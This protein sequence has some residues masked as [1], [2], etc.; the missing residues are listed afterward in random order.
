MLLFLGFVF[1]FFL[2]GFSFTDTDNSQD[3]REGAFF[4]TDY[5]SPL[6][7]TH[8]HSDIYLQ[9]WM[10]D[11]YHI[12]LIAPLVFTT[13]LSSYHLIYDAKFLFVY[14]MIWD[15]TILGFCYNSLDTENRWTRTHIDYYTYIASKQ[16]NKLFTYLTCAYLKK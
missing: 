13:I 1:C 16:T 12:F 6:P 10:W 3:R 15:I 7:R 14:L 2:S 11:D 9:L 4:I 5:L 8:K